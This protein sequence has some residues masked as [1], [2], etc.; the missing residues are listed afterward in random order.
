MQLGLGQRAA[1][2][3]VLHQIPASHHRHAGRLA[4]RAHRIAEA[5]SL[6]MLHELLGVLRL[7]QQHV[8]PGD[9]RA[10]QP[11]AGQCRETGERDTM[12]RIVAAGL[13]DQQVGILGEDPG[14]PQR[15]LHGGLA[16]HAAIGDD[17]R[18]SGARE[19]REG[20]RQ[21]RRIARGGRTGAD[22]LG[23]GRAER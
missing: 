21:Q 13:P 20:S 2:Q 19:C 7:D 10:P 18:R 16:A 1:C 15:H 8:D 6:R 12:Q 4:E 14:Q 5:N 9:P 11:V 23:G 3:P 17:R 22:P